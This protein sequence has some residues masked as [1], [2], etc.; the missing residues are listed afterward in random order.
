MTKNF[1][2]IFGKGGFGTVYYG[3]IDDTKQIKILL[4]VHHGNLTSLVGYC[5]EENN[6]ALVYEYMENGNLQSYLSDELSS[7]IL[8][9]EDRLRIAIDAAQ[10][11]EY[12]HYGCKPPI[13][14]RDVKC[15]NILLNEKNQAK[16][17][18]FGL[19][20]IFPTD[21]GTHVSTVVAGTFGYLDPETHRLNE[22]SDVYSYGVV[23]LEIITGRPVILKTNDNIH[24]GQWVKLMLEK[25]EIKSI[26][27]PRLQE[28][29]NMNSAWKALEIAMNCI[30]PSSSERPTMNQVVEELKECLEISLVKE[31]ETQPRDPIEVVPLNLMVDEFS[32][33]SPR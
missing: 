3:H 2:K 8:K 10:G 28:N 16:L 9:W 14:H 31:N 23:L 13:I 1:E 17:S 4:R 25:G 5:N 7:K 12:L 32:G 15:T 11:L 26:I 18:D 27:D 29:F 6:S 22:K 19:S 21:S 24:I 30:S 33:P 20:K